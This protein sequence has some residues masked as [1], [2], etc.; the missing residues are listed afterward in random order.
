MDVVELVVDGSVP[1]F[2][3]GQGG[4]TDKMPFQMK[5]KTRWLTRL[6]LELPWGTHRTPYISRRPTRSKSS[7]T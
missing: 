6:A 4:H 7:V 3:D 2:P 5:W 1:P